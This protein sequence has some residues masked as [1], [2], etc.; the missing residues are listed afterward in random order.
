MSTFKSKNL[1]A[2]EAMVKRVF[3]RVGQG[4]REQSELVASVCEELVDILVMA[5][6][7]AD[8]VEEIELSMLMRPQRPMRG[9][10]ERCE[11]GMWI[12]VEH[13]Y[14]RGHQYYIFNN[15]KYVFKSFVR[16]RWGDGRETV[17]HLL[18]YPYAAEIEEHGHRELVR[19]SLEVIVQQAP[20]GGKLEV[21]RLSE[22]DIWLEN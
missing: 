13:I 4:F 15:T 8:R 9:V 20:D 2:R 14:V 21:V 16:V 7:L 10:I 17:E 6:P 5:G 18:E 3:E 22:V 19:G 11:D 12:R 1:V